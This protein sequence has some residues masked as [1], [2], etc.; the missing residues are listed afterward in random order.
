MKAIRVKTRPA[1]ILKTDKPN[2]LR[3][4]IPT[5]K[6]FQYKGRKLLAVKH[7]LDNTIKLR[8]LGYKTPS[9]ILYD[10]NWSGRYT[11]FKHQSE[12]AEFLTLNH[13]AF[14]L[15]EIGTGK[16][17]A[18][19]WATDYLR[20]IG[21]VNRVLIV[22]PL[23]TLERVWGDE[24][25]TH[26]MGDT[27]AVLH[28]TAAKR[29][30]LLSQDF[31]YYIINHDG[32]QIVVDELSNRDDINHIIV[33][34]CTAYRNSRIDRYKIFYKYISQHPDTRLWMMTGTPT[35]NAPT[36]AWAQCRLVNPDS[37]PRYFGRF[38]DVVMTKVSTYKWV[39]KKN[40]VE[41][42]KNA[43][44]PAVRYTRDECLDLPD[45]IYQT[46][47]CKLSREQ[48]KAYKEMAQLLWT[49][50]GDGSVTAANEAVK[51]LKLI[52]VACG[53]VY[54]DQGKGNMIDAGPRL[55]LLHEVIEE[56][57]EK[58][59]VFVPFTGVLNMI[60]KFIAKNWTVDYVDGTVSAP[61]RNK[62]FQLFQKSN[63]PHVLVAHPRTMSH[64][65]TLTAAT[66]VIWYAPYPSVETYIQANGRITREGQTKTTNIVH[67]EATKMERDIY[68]RLNNNQKMQGLLLDAIQEMM[69]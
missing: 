13:R 48:E 51:M 9:P 57:G 46:R 6:Q 4:V 1:L 64:G 69:D 33:D 26:F 32:F 60:V 44:Q 19:L 34:E 5:A 31:D 41:L 59:I 43:M 30:R 15:N 38:R 42:V 27:Y 62:I 47:E 50:V 66:T 55:N 23:S 36:D 21:K 25:F 17:L 40:A 68:N 35:P 49:Q 22:S 52:Q 63:D 20:Q 54:D 14:V 37:V 24:I 28:G 58:V 65:L 67:F 39:P 53:V 2:Q 11:P 16:S 7:T 12:T 8:G 45:T 56:A 61:R 3:T 18:A 10:Y 29:K